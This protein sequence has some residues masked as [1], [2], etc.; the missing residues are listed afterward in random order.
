M[1]AENSVYKKSTQALSLPSVNKLKKAAEKFVKRTEIYFRDSRVV[2]LRP[3][4]TTRGRVL[5]SYLLDPFVVD[6]DRLAPNDPIRWHSNAWECREIAQTFLDKG[7]I[8]DATNFTNHVFDPRSSYDVLIDTRRNIERLGGSVGE[9]CL[10][11]FHVDTANTVFGNMAEYRRLLGIQER[12]GVTLQPRRIDTPNRGM[13][14]ADV[15]TVLGNKFTMET[16]SFTKTPMHRIP[17]SSPLDVPFPARKNFD[18]VRRS[19]VWIGSSGLVRKG[20]DVILEA[21]AQMPNFDLYVCGS[22]GKRAGKSRMGAWFD[23]EEDFEAAYYRELYE[24]PN[25]HTLG[26]IDTNSA[27]FAD[28]ADR[29]VGMAYAS[30]AEGQCGGVITCMHWGLIPVISYESGV[31]VDDHGFLFDSCSIEDIKRKVQQVAALPATELEDRARA[32]WRYARAHHTRQ[33]FARVY[34]ETVSRIMAQHSPDR[35]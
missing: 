32:T 34:R 33:N 19:F 21:F 15:A 31:D 13:E 9:S 6:W 10:K 14:L 22:I 2:T 4:G 5:L 1:V 35:G 25:I 24:T 17:L 11:I 30:C 7:F 8:V 26:W 27:A 29:C 20:L 12:R 16:F 3:Q 28:I 23:I 18:Q